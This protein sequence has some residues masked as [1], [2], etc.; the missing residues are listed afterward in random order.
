MGQFDLRIQ[1]LLFQSC[2]AI[3][4]GAMVLRG[5]GVTSPCTGSACA[6]CLLAQLVGVG[7]LLLLEGRE[8]GTSA[9]LAGASVADWERRFTASRRQWLQSL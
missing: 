1:A 3:M 4:T 6:P 2:L 9:T 8:A 5:L 7:S